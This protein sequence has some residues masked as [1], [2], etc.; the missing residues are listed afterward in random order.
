MRRRISVAMILMVV[1]TLFLAGVLTLLLT[2]HQSREQTRKELVNEGTSLAATVRQEATVANQT[3]PA[4]SLHN[5][6]VALK[7]P[8]RLQDEAVLAVRPATGRIFDPANPG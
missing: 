4:R 3:D 6:L 7:G 1:G 2:I 5:I 8:L